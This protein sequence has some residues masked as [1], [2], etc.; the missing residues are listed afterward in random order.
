[1]NV[2]I[3]YYEIMGVPMDADRSTIKKAYR[4]LAEQYH[5]DRVSTLGPKLKEVAEQEMKQINEARSILLDED[6]RKVYDEA[7]STFNGSVA[8]DPQAMA[9]QQAG[10]WAG[11]I[12][13]DFRQTGEMLYNAKQAGLD[14]RLAAAA[15]D[16]AN[17]WYNHGKAGKARHLLA[18][19]R[20]HITAQMQKRDALGQLRSAREILALAKRLGI[21]ISEMYDMLK[22]GQPALEAQDFVTLQYWVELAR[23]TADE[24]I[25]EFLAQEI[26]ETKKAISQAQNAGLDSGP[27]EQLFANI[28]PLIGENRLEEALRVAVQIQDMTDQLFEDNEEQLI[29]ELFG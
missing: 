25:Q 28:K 22:Q 24:K 26:I 17:H 13:D 29:D 6:Q 15:M 21:D 7:R 3:D 23:S 11:D 12:M 1:M 16:E 19:S 10:I 5:P 18:D 20:N 27:L 2:N 8:S 9:D 4:S 14:V